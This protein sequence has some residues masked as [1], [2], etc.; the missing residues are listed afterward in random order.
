MFGTFAA[1][2]SHVYRHHRDAVGLETFPDMTPSA[3]PCV[4]EADTA[5]FDEYDARVFDTS[6]SGST[7]VPE[8]APV[9]SLPQSDP[10][11]SSTTRA[12]K[13]LLHL[14]EGRKVSE[15][16]LID[17]IDICNA[18]CRH[19][20]SNFKQEIREKC[21]QANVDVELLEDIK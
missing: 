21:T 20:V 17:V 19:V 7:S 15:V 6:T 16:A 4:G 2:N 18:M 13:F 12:A 10:G 14:R 3:E 8:F 5:T 11:P 1:Y 9:V